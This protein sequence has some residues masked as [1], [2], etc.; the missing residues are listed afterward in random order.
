VCPI[1]KS[2]NKEFNALF[3]KSDRKNLNKLLN[4]YKG[5]NHVSR[6]TLSRDFPYTQIS[7]YDLR[8]DYE[9][10]EEDIEDAKRKSRGAEVN[11]WMA[12]LYNGLQK[13]DSGQSI[14][15]IYRGTN[16]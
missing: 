6:K 2:Y 9:K 4:D 8:E 16:D 3:K 10:A 7:S 15:D 11:P 12:G 13:M 5:K 14:A 1:A